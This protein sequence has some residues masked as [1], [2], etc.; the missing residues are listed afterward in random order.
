MSCNVKEGVTLEELL[1]MKYDAEFELIEVI[2]REMREIRSQTGISIRDVKV[3]L[4]NIALSGDKRNDF[5]V[6][7]VNLTLDLEERENEPLP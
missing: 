3:D 2:N 4:T 6:S 5:V 7:N 1:D